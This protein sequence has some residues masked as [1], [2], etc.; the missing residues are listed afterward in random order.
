MTR[1]TKYALTAAAGVIVA[2]VGGGLFTPGA[3]TEIGAW[4]ASLRKP[5]FQPPNWLFAPVWTLLYVL[6]VVSA[7]RLAK[8]DAPVRRRLLTLWW[9]QLAVNAIW[10][11]LFFGARRPAAALVVIAV[12]LVLLLVYTRSAWKE[13]RVAA[14]C[15]LPYIAWVS[16]ASV[17]NFEIVR[18]M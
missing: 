15:F 11:P 4:Y 10:T 3:G 6:M 12:L 5:P 17:L 2:S 14:A 16:F 18:R 8:L 9:V 7:A 1:T 13:D